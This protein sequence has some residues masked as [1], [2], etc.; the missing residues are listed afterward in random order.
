MARKEHT[1][2]INRDILDGLIR[3]RGAGGAADFE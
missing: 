3:E 2:G 1:E